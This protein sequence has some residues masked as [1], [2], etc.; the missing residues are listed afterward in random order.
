MQN[1]DGSGLWWRMYYSF[2]YLNT[3]GYAGHL[4]P[5]VMVRPA[6]LAGGPAVLHTCAEPL[7]ALLSRLTSEAVS[8]AEQAQCRLHLVPVLTWLLCCRARLAPTLPRPTTSS[9]WPTSLRMRA[10]T[11][12]PAWLTRLCRYCHLPS[13]PASHLVARTG[14]YAGLRSQEHAVQGL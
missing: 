6:A 4:F 9:P 14:S 12:T 5:V 1:Y 13:L 8:T 2:G 7:P 3:V 10:Q 11:P